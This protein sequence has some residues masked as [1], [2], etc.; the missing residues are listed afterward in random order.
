[1][2]KATVAVPAASLP[3]SLQARFLSALTEPMR[4]QVVWLADELNNSGYDTICFTARKAVCLADSLVRIGYLRQTDKF[5]ST[6]ILDV[7]CSHL[8]GKRVML[9]EDVVSSG[10]TMLRTLETLQQYGP[11]TLGCIALSAEGRH[12]DLNNELRRRMP[13]LNLKL[14]LRSTPSESLRHARSLVRGFSALPRPFNID[15]PIYRVDNVE[16]PEMNIPYALRAPAARDSFE[17]APTFNL[18]PNERQLAAIEDVFPAW[19]R[20]RQHLQMHKLRVYPF[21]NSS[22]ER[23]S[24]FVVPIAALGPMTIAEIKE[25]YALV[26]EQCGPPLAETSSP[27]EQYRCLQYI[28]STVLFLAGIDVN[29]FEPSIDH[30]A[31]AQY[32]FAPRHHG[33]L[34]AALASVSQSLGPFSLPSAACNRSIQGVSYVE[35]SI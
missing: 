27:S 29:R 2:T 9:V 26:A 4:R 25:V 16:S 18:M 10:R 22:D 34:K 14:Q 15:W 33:N 31:D 5:C 28:L 3:G 20:V 7:D 12:D 32:L 17:H 19:E 21:P 24:L 6:R 30:V 35:R 8:R 23:N 11:H 1:M 13:G